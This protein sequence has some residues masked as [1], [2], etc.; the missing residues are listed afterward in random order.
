MSQN[1]GQGRAGLKEYFE[2]DKMPTEDH[3]A[4]LIDASLNKIDDQLTLVDSGSGENSGRFLGIGSA[5]PQSPL[6]VRNRTGDAKLIGLE[7]TGGTEAWHISIN[8]ANSN[9][10]LLLTNNT[11]PNAALMM[12]ADGNVGIGTQTPG[13]KLDV[14]GNV[15][16]TNGDLS[17]TNGDLDIAT[18]N[19]SLDTGDADIGGD[20]AVE[21][22]IGIGTDIPGEKLDVNGSVRVTTGNLY[23][24]DGSLSL[25]NGSL[26]L[27]TG[28]ANIAGSLAVDGNTGIGTNTPGEKLDVNGNARITSGDLYLTDGNVNMA[29]GDLNVDT[30]NAVVGGGLTVNGNTGIGT[31]AP[32]EKLEV[33]GNVRVTNGSLAITDG[34]LD[35]DTGNLSLTTGNLN[36]ATGNADIAG[37]LSVGGS[38]NFT[39]SDL[40]LVN[41]SLNIAIGDLSIDTGS[42]N[43]A[44]NLSVV[45]HTG[46]GTAPDPAFR[47]DVSGNVRTSGNL[48]LTTGSADIA[49]DLSVGGNINFTN[50]D[51]NLANGNLVL[52]TGSADIAGSLTV[53]GNINFTN[54]DLNLANGNLVLGTGSAD[55]A[56]GL[57][58]EG[59]TGMGTAPDP[60]FR[61]DVSGDLRSS[62]SITAQSFIGDFSWNSITDVPVPV[63]NFNGDL[64]W[65]NVTGKPN[66][67]VPSG[68][69]MVW[70]G[71]AANVPNTWVACDGQNGTPN[72]NG[73]DLL[74]IM[75]L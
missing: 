32:T 16:V 67:L 70:S 24:T 73:G 31:D 51:L 17:L 2:T 7:D 14:S 65:A 49:G 40:N 58:V 26:N 33:A 36:L 69:I 44:A 23:L 8:P 1:Q 13:E 61:L 34:S 64:P 28:D 39:N 56:G 10:G 42:A 62:G 75:K 6:S 19:L 74:Y 15:R 43:I 71:D 68:V 50:S 3:F 66:S 29:L 55:I 18:G 57:T 21:G 27:D 22:N 46:M 72:L 53:G 47:L 9:N 30:G 5:D 35:I 12:E 11:N 63:Q 52:D 54:S 45:G 20:L 59:N 38:I 25:V 60:A 4:D 41:G 48:S 37:D